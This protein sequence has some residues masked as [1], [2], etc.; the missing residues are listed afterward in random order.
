MRDLP[1]VVAIK[2]G[3]IPVEGTPTA[4]KNLGNGFI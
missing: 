3:I 1:E 4:G 2:P